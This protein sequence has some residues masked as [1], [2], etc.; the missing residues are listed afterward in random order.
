MNNTV[1]ADLG[2]ATPLILQA[3]GKDMRGAMVRDNVLT[4]A[5]TS[6]NLLISNDT[7]TNNSGVMAFNHCKHLDTTGGHLLVPAG[8]VISPFD[9][10]S[11]SVVTLQGLILPVVDS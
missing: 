6:G 2:T 11:T 3:T 8:G 7:T 9:N 5:T 1:L 10:K 4:S